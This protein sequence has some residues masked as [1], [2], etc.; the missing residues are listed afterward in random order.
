[1]AKLWLFLTFRTSSI[2][3]W[4]QSLKNQSI[5]AQIRE[6]FM[7]ALNDV[8]TEYKSLI[9]QPT[10]EPQLLEVVIDTN[11][12][13][14]LKYGTVALKTVSEDGIR[15]LLL[16]EACHVSTLP[17]SLI[18]IVEIGGQQGMAFQRDNVTNYDEY[19]A[20]IEF[21]TKFRDDPRF[22]A[23]LE[24]QYELTKNFEIIAKCAKVL[25]SKLQRLT[26]QIE[27]NFREQINNIAYDSLFFHV[28][29][30]PAMSKWFTEQ[31]LE[32]LWVYSKW[33]HE[34]FEFIRK[35]HFR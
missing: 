5:E 9:L 14:V 7:T 34:D 6:L 33:I 15:A 10:T 17:N 4:A 27:W 29:G 19:L 21:V 13:L 26:K 3:R 22:K 31:S 2:K 25:A 23:L 32:G 24:Q 20:N 1:M 8:G 12:D 28:S 35:W 30:D 16:H 18:S 11:R